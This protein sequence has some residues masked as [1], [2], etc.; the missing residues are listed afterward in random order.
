MGWVSGL[1]I[2]FIIWWTSLFVILPLGQRSQADADDITL[3]TTHS[4]PAQHRMGWKLLQTTILACVVF[5]A[6]YVVTQVYGLSPDDFPKMIPG[7]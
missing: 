4:A 7:T 2:Y 5:A 3:G 6:F 1:A